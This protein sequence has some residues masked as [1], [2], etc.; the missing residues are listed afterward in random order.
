[1]ST[2]ERI[3]RVSPVAGCEAKKRYRAMPDEMPLDYTEFAKYIPGG[4]VTKEE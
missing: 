4:E 3:L 1:M 2:G